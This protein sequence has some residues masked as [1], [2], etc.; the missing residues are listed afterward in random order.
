LHGSPD[1]VAIAKESI[2]NQEQT[3]KLVEKLPSLD[4]DGARDLVCQAL[5]IYT[6]HVAAGSHI[7][8]AEYTGCPLCNIENWLCGRNNPRLKHLFRI[9]IRLGIP[10]DSLFRSSGPTTS[11]VMTAREVVE[12]AGR[13]KSNR[14]RKRDK[15]L[16]VLESVLVADPPENLSQL[17]RRLGYANSSSLS[18]VDRQLA[19][20]IS[21]RTRP[22]MAQE[23]SK[24][25]F[26]RKASKEAVRLSLEQALAVER[27]LS[28]RVIALQLGYGDNYR[29]KKDCPD[30]CEQIVAKRRAA[31]EASREVLRRSL[32]NALKEIP[33]PSIA[34]IAERLSIA[35]Q[36]IWRWEPAMTR[37]LSQRYAQCC[38]E[39]I[40]DLRRLAE[41]ALKD[42]SSK[43]LGTVLRD[44]GI[45][46]K[47]MEAQ[48]PEV[49]SAIAEKYRVSIVERNERRREWMVKVIRK[50]VKELY[51][52]GLSPT[53]KRLL[54]REPALWP[55]GLFN[56]STELRL[57]CSEVER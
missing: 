52:E 19:K 3:A 26:K 36:V 18:K 33:T 57:A 38:Q 40:E 44:L 43:P 8:F 49:G 24:R 22:R 4:P 9:S 37:K 25:C 32:S 54:C 16:E 50:V 47:L 42:P 5:N 11:E 56:L 27:P 53:V 34:A 13:W 41:T 39:Q 15:V 51:G 7:R 23:I 14:H 48:F 35:A 17:A 29:I 31:N 6:D 55:C 45:G 20:L 1:G 2:W 10:I 30:L 12:N 46:R 21:E 28:L